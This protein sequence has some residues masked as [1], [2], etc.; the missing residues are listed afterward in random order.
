MRKIIQK[1]THIQTHLCM[2]YACVKTSIQCVWLWMCMCTY[3]MCA[4]GCI[5]MC[6]HVD[7]C[8]Y[9]WCCVYSTYLRW[10]F[11]CV[12]GLCL[13]VCLCLYVFISRFFCW[14]FICVLP[15]T[16]TSP[17]TPACSWRQ[18]SHTGPWC[19]AGQWSGPAWRC[20]LPSWA[21]GS[22]R[23]PAHPGSPDVVGTEGKEQGEG[24]GGRRKSHSY[25]PASRE[26]PILENKDVLLSFSLNFKQLYF[27]IDSI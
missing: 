1:H 13:Y 17:Q 4:P 10:V 14:M 7:K 8:V 23:S 16:C 12:C 11:I 21:A 6:I 5:W 22:A 20:P 19:P 25:R 26:A 2:F 9:V 24:R 27:R 18:W 3:C 15:W